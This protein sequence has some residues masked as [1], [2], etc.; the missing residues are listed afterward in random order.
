MRDPEIHVGQSKQT[1]QNQKNIKHLQSNK[2]WSPKDHENFQ[3]YR[4]KSVDFFV[5]F[6]VC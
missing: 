4:E 1:Q 2:G 6:L 3:H 5:K